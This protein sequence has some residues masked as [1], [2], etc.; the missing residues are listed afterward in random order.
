MMTYTTSVTLKCKILEILSLGLHRMAK[1]RKQKTT[2][3]HFSSTRK[4]NLMENG[5]LTFLSQVQNL[6]N[7][8]PLHFDILQV[9]NK[10]A[11][12]IM[13]KSCPIPLNNMFAG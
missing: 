3:K 13:E 5:S 2:P 12:I 9:L 11:W 8:L 4:K 6:S 1:N 10:E 7:D